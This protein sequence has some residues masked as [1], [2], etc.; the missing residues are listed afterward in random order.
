MTTQEQ[1][2][3][4][5][6]NI[7]FLRREHHLSRTAMA[8]KI[9][10]TVKTLDSLEQEIWPDRISIRILFRIRMCF[11]ITPTELLTICLEASAPNETQ[12]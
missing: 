12:K 6:R 2:Q 4:A 7:R 8:R 9:G 5:C 11:G 10:I 3:N 1:L